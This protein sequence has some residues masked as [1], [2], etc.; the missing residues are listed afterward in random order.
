MLRNPVSRFSFEITWMSYGTSVNIDFLRRS[1]G[2]WLTTAEESSSSL[3][4]LFS[5]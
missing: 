3:T 2:K 4:Y 5:K 1:G